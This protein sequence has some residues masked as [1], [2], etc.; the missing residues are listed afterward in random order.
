MGKLI[1]DGNSVYE[2]DEECM[3]RKYPSGMPIYVQNCT[4]TE[5]KEDQEEAE[6]KRN[7]F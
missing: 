5:K 6:E 3:K 1:I 2:V 4:I 7:A